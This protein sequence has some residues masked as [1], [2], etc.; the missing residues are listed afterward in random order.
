MKIWQAVLFWLLGFGF[1]LLCMSQVATATMQEHSWKNERH[2]ALL[3]GNDLYADCQ[4]AEKNV[5]ARD[6]D[7]IYSRG[8]SVSAFAAGNCWGYVA[9]VVDSIPGGEGF[10]PDEHVKLTQHVD[11]VLKYLREYP[12]E[13]HKPAYY[14]A[15]TALENAFP[16]RKIK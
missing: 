8:D 4:Q 9:A 16:A 15:R 12:A 14:L 11:V 13:R 5:E 3:H 2:Y 7:T 6:G 1:A 10:A